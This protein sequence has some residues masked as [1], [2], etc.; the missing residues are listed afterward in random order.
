MHHSDGALGA[1]YTV[2]EWRRK[3]LARL[4]ITRRLAERRFSTQGKD[5]QQYC[6]VFRGNHASESLWLRMGWKAAWGVKWVVNRE[7]DRQR[8]KVVIHRDEHH[9]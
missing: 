8:G 3:G 6:H 2:P 4:V 5:P 9:P 1:L 7:L